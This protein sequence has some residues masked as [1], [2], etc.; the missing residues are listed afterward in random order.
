MYCNDINIDELLRQFQE[1]GYHLT[2]IRESNM[3]R[4]VYDGI[5]VGTFSPD[6]Y[7][8]NDY[9]VVNIGKMVDIRGKQRLYVDSLDYGT[10]VETIIDSIRKYTAKSGVLNEK[11]NILVKKQKR[12]MNA[13]QCINELVTTNAL[14]PYLTGYCTLENGQICYGCEHGKFGAIIVNSDNVFFFKKTGLDKQAWT[15]LNTF[16]FSPAELVDYKS[17][18]D[19]IF[20]LP[21]KRTK[22]YWKF[23]W[24]TLIKYASNWIPGFCVGNKKFFLPR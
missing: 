8:Y 15:Y 16:D 22:K 24:K 21:M 1:K 20:N 19:E 4:L 13:I 6:L 10:I 5:I 17:C 14:A 2:C 12:S 7:T 3:E 23:T 11:R 18:I 9:D